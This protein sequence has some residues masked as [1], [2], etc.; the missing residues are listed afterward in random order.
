MLT[1]KTIM[2]VE[3]LFSFFHIDVCYTVV[4]VKFGYLASLMLL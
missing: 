4:V 2:K 1:Y 3:I